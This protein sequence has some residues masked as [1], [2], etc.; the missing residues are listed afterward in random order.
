MKP[1]L[2]FVILCVYNGEKYKH[3]CCIV[4]A[5]SK[6][7]IHSPI[8]KFNNLDIYKST[9]TNNFINNL[10]NLNNFLL[11]TTGTLILTG[12][13]SV[14]VLSAYY[15]TTNIVRA[16]KN[17]NNNSNNDNGA[18]NNFHVDDFALKQTNLRLLRKVSWTVS[19]LCGGKLA[20]DA[21]SI[22]VMIKFLHVLLLLVNRRP[23]HKNEDE[24][25]DHRDEQNAD[26]DNNNH[27]NKDQNNNGN[28]EHP[29]QQEQSIDD[30]D[31]MLDSC[32][33]LVLSHKKL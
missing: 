1:E 26:H 23:R 31:I 32:L 25:N 7:D 21:E 29:L 20:R 8:R 22:K 30:G 3:A 13:N 14:Y 2:Y 11:Y 27:N 33:D 16:H 5:A 19:S 15:F 6:N 9:S 12:I 28:N 10:N 18:D 4:K 17:N 24:E